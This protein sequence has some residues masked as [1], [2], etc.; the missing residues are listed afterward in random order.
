[1]AWALQFD[2]V[3]DL[4]SGFA[5]PIL[6][7]NFSVSMWVKM[8]NTT[9]PTPFFQLTDRFQGRPSLIVGYVPS[10]L[11]IN[12]QSWNIEWN[13][14]NFG[15][16]AAD[17]DWHNVI[18]TYD[19]TLKILVIYWDGVVILNAA[20]YYINYETGEINLARASDWGYIGAKSGN[21]NTTD[22]AV[23][24]TVLTQTQATAMQVLGTAS[25]DEVQRYPITESVGTTSG[26]IADPI[27]NI[28]M[29]LLNMIAP[30]GVVA[31]AP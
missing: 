27:G 3:N 19:Y 18:I 11:G 13:L 17:N 12:A 22:I 2:G 15:T 9:L 25:G 30:Y 6:G 20:T 10:L 28:P 8:N 16:I 21:I 1:M 24:N 14:Y 4:T 29:Q 5:L 26:Y 23:H 31:D 7:E